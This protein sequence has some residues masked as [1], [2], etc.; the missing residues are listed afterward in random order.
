MIAVNFI[1][2]KSLLFQDQNEKTEN[3][4]RPQPR[5]TSLTND[6]SLFCLTQLLD[7]L[8][9]IQLDFSRNPKRYSVLK[10]QNFSSE[11]DKQTQPDNRSPTVDLNKKVLKTS[12]R[13]K[14]VRF[15]DC[16]GF[17]LTQIKEY[18]PFPK[19]DF[20]VRE[21]PDDEFLQLNHPIYEVSRN[22]T[23][24][25]LPLFFLPPLNAALVQKALEKN[26]QLESTF[27]HGM[28][29]NGSILVANLSFKKEIYLRF[30]FDNWS[31]FEENPADYC[32]SVFMENVEQHAV[33]RFT[34]EITFENSDYQ[35]CIGA[36][37]CFCVRFVSDLGE[38][39]DNNEGLNYSLKLV[40]T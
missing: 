7:E 9:S 29:L 32:G 26:V 14:S 34:F 23:K 1:F 24:T 28:I 20:S 10:K 40:E 3:S 30:S 25:L 19:L 15:A 21:E 6:K 33:D 8:L 16:C 18:Q 5:Y 36:K 22:L 35:L 17:K 31:T 38:F 2:V 11:L 37:I 13:S 4:K 39:W 12:R 27:I